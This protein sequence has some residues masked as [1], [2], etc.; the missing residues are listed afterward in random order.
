MEARLATDE[1]YLGRYVLIEYDTDGS[2][3][4]DTYLKCYVKNGANGEEFYTSPN[5]ETQTRVKWSKT[6]AAGE[7]SVSGTVTTGDLIYVE[8]DLTPEDKKTVISQV[9]YK[10]I[11]NNNSNNGDIAEF[12]L[13]S[14]GESNYTKNYNIDT[15]VYGEGRGY[16]STVWQ[17]V[18]TQGTEKY[19]M[20]AEL[21]SVVPTFD[22]TADAPTMNPITPHFDADSTNVYYKL[23]WQPQWGFRVAEA[24]GEN[25]DVQATWKTASYDP[26]T[27][28]I[29]ST[30][31]TV[32]AAINFNGPAFDP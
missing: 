21:N 22:I 7:P 29:T 4:L 19:V 6:D 23:H 14:A 20:I 8:K 11:N 10:C 5:F 1:I 16:D 15:G 13:I 18:Y 3:T 2:H 17:K 9:F 12:K 25:S 28:K 31:N 27:D 32:D 26:S 24:N 30:E